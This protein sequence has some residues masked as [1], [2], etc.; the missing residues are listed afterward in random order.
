MAAKPISIIA[1]VA[2]SGTAE[3]ALILPYKSHH[4]Y[5]NLRSPIRTTPD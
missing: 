3:I 1:Q 2:D 4:Q 5:K